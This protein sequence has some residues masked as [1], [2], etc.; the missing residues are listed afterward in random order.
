[1]AQL[2][3]VDRAILSRILGV[4]ERTMQRMLVDSG[5]HTAPTSKEALLEGSLFRPH[6]F[7]LFDRST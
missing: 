4:S 6:R 1:M 7:P 5:R 3:T 2:L